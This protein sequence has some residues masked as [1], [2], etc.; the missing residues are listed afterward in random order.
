MVIVH[1]SNLVAGKRLKPHRLVVDDA[2]DVSHNQRVYLTAVS[3]QI[4]T[5]TPLSH[6]THRN[7]S[8]LTEL[9]VEKLIS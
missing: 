6:C 9:T 2:L 1:C 8:R 7:I 4:N 5:N 3:L